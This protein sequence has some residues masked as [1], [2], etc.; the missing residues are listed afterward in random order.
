MSELTK[1][2]MI[3][4]VQENIGHI[5]D[6]SFVIYFYVL[7]T[8]G[9]PS[10][11]LEYIYQTAY[12]LKELGYNVVMLYDEDELIGVGD[13]FGQKYADLPHK[14]VPKEGR[15]AEP[16]EMRA[17]DFVIIPEIFANVMISLKDKVPCKKIVLVQNYNWL[18]ESM[19]MVATF[20]NLKINDIITTTETQ[21]K[22]LESYFP[23]MN[24]FVV[25]PS[26]SPMFRD[27][28]KQRNLAIN[29]IARNQSDV[30]RILKPFHWKYPVYN[31]VTF[32]DLRGMTQE[33]FC[34]QLR[35]NAITIWIDE[36]SNFG[37]SALEALRCGSIVLCKVPKKLTDWQI[38]TDENGKIKMTDACIWFEDIDDVPDML[39]SI[40][41]TWTLD[42]I[43]EQVYK[44][45]HKFDDYYSRDKQKNEI[46]YVY[47]KNIVEKRVKDF[48]EVLVQL[49]NNKE[50]EEKK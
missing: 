9:N 49:K 42:K 50:I 2:Q 29:I 37:Y 32:Q 46:E 24:I 12:T 28:D 27:N 25:S 14:Q 17:C 4:I 22:I 1:K 33:L 10:G 26:I 21:K 31:W 18:C 41:R 8:K 36:E 20:Q 30:H 11:S 7:D 13:W 6:K 47:I 35:N 43:P 34:E 48:E 44:Q 5:K 40:I 16:I 19:P 15:K 45:Q 38:E 39:S 23:N 3:D